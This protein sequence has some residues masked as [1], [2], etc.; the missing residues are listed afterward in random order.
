MWWGSRYSHFWLTLQTRLSSLYN[1]LNLVNFLD[2]LVKLQLCLHGWLR[3]FFLWNCQLSRSQ[4]R[5]PP[6]VLGCSRSYELRFF[7]SQFNSL[8]WPHSFNNIGPSE[9]NSFLVLVLP[10]WS[11]VL[12]FSILRSSVFLLFYL[13]QWS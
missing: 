7:P 5:L 2:S 4:N 1:L 6:E 8:L 3:K 12:G 11:L 13:L 10:I 9:L